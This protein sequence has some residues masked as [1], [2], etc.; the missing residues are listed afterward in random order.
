MTAMLRAVL[1]FRLSA[2]RA[3]Q[4]PEIERIHGRTLLDE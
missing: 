3:E 1:G 2:S 4:D